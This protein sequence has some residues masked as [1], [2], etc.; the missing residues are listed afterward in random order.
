[1]TTLG[2]GAE[3]IANEIATLEEEVVRLDSTVHALRAATR[4]TESV[5]SA[6]Q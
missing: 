6:F 5:A 3:A 4:V 1:M 2:G